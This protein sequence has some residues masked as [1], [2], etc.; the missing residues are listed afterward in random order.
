[1]YSVQKTTPEHIGLLCETIREEDRREGWRSGRMFT[2]PALE[3]SIAMTNHPCTLLYKDIVLY[4]FG[5]G[6]PSPLSTIAIPWG[7]GSFLV[8]QHYR[9]FSKV[10]KRF[11]KYMTENFTSSI[12][13]VDSEYPAAVRWLAWTGYTIHPSV[14]FG[15]AGELFHPFTWENDV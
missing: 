4:I 3:A 9:E 5:H 7:M 15:P 14:P 12:N 2:K 13:Y 1:M 6:S 10:S 8:P 11:F